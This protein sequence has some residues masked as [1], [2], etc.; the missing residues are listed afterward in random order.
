MKNAAKI[1]R[2]FAASALSSAA[3]LAAGQST[4]AP[5]L[6]PQLKSLQGYWEGEGAGG[7]CY[8]TITNNILYYRNAKDWF[9]TTFTL[10]DNTSP[11]QL[12]A[13]IKNSSEGTRSNG[14]VVH[15]IFKV[16]N[17]TLTLATIDLNEIPP[18]DFITARDRYIVKKTTPPKDHKIADCNPTSKPSAQRETNLIDSLFKFPIPPPPPA[19]GAK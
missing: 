5:P 10:P 13:T 6:D 11:R 8:I 15:A 2:V 3:L 17:D 14:D 12:H 4:S 16:E 9:K 1:L 19:P 18:R 7:K